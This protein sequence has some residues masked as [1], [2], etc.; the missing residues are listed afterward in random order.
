MLRNI[1]L[2]FILLGANIGQAASNIPRLKLEYSYALDMYCPLRV[3]PETLKPSQLALIPKIPIYR[4]E[5]LS[6]VGWFQNQWNIQGN[7]L[8]QATVKLIGKPFPMSELQAAIFLCP[9]LPFMGTP[10]SL[11]VISYLESSSKDIE[12]LGKPLPIFF[13]VSTTIHEVLHKYINNILDKNG[14]PILA[15]MKET[16]LYKS[17]L[18]LF[19]VQKLVFESL[20]LTDLLQPIGHLEAL[21]GPDYVKAWQTVHG[22]QKIYEALLLELKK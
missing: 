1:I 3:E 5:L 17:H 13:F 20:G 4:N 16:D 15:R 9:R 22:D 11:N 19:A 18:H 21:H 7:P 14:S 2:L 10:L 8:L 12:G 6:K